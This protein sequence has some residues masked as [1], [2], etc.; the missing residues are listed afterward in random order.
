MTDLERRTRALRDAGG[1]AVRMEASGAASAWGDRITE[2]GQVDARDGKTG[3]D[4]VACHRPP[5]AAAR[6]QRP[7]APRA[8]GDRLRRR[9]D[10]GS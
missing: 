8:A 5:G 4:Q 7:P 2:R 3:L 9:R 1:V 6:V 10:R